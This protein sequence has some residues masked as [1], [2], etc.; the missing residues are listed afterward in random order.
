MD[1]QTIIVSG[2][3]LAA[4]FYVGMMSWG[5]I[6]SFSPKNACGADCGCE[7]SSRTSKLHLKLK[8]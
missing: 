5:K 7:S 8:N 2:I 6:K 1:I 3:I 4:L